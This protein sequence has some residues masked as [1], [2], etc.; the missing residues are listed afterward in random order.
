MSCITYA[1]IG[2]I[3]MTP[4]IQHYFKVSIQVSELNDRIRRLR[5]DEIMVGLRFKAINRCHLRLKELN[6]ELK[7]ARTNAG[8][9]WEE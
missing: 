5:R 7:K 4:Q 1:K 8:L 2:I 3:N 9:N 6:K